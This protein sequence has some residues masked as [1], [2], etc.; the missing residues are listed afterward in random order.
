[1]TRIHRLASLLFISI[2]FVLATVACT[3]GTTTGATL[4]G[5]TNTTTGSGTT[6][7]GQTTTA[8]TTTEATEPESLVG[9][10]AIDITNLGMPLIF[11]LKIE[12]DDTF[13]L[14]SDRTYSVDKGHGTI[15][16]SGD[17]YMFIYSDSTV[18]DPKTSTFTV[19]HSNLH[20]TT[21]LHY[22]ASNLPASKED[23]DNPEIIYYLVAKTLAN[24][25]Y[26]GEYVGA[27]SVTA[28]ASTIDYEYSLILESGNEYSFLSQYEVGGE[29]MEYTEAGFYQI[30]GTTLTLQHPSEGDIV[31]T[32]STEGEISIGIKPAEEADRAERDLQLAITAS[33][34]GTYTGYKKLV[35]GAMTVYETSITLVLDK[36]GGYVYT[37]VDTVSGGIEETGSF[38]IS[39]S[40]LT[41]TPSDSETPFT[42][43]LV[44]YQLTT[45][46]P[47]QLE[48]STRTS[49]KLYCQTVQGTFS[50]EGEDEAENTYTATVNLYPDGTF[51]LVVL[52]SEANELLSDDGTFVI[53]GFM[54]N[55]TGGEIYSTVISAV[56]INV[57]FEVAPEVEVGFIL[58]KVTIGE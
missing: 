52:D 54:L 26:F 38:T 3:G 4:P 25:E 2:C 12:S 6:Q 49:V 10:Y 29:L 44:N 57:N 40:T 39:G 53:F 13:Q 56:G 48:A 46:L 47:L 30:Q 55:L 58:K 7:P 41:F 27:H 16:H 50:G 21:S 37:G 8:T 28:M 19:E 33:C 20:F 43:S 36:F 51:D 42:G 31:G 17:T 14:G 1:M 35:E 22:G 15:G 18:Q 32:I 5:T 24:S 9:E 45:E 11:F 23:E 34:A